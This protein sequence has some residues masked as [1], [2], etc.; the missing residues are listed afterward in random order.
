MSKW[1]LLVK[2]IGCYVSLK[3]KPLTQRRKDAEGAKAPHAQSAPVGA[4]RC[5]APRRALTKGKGG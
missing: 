5:R 4:R 3:E 1:V 2:H